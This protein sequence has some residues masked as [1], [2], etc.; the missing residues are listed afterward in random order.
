MFSVEAVL[1]ESSRSFLRCRARCGCALVAVV[2]PGG[3]SGLLVRFPGPVLASGDPRAVNARAVK[4]LI[5]RIRDSEISG[6][7]A[8]LE[9]SSGSQG[10]SSGASAKKPH[11]F[12]APR[13]RARRFSIAVKS[14][15][16]A[17]A[18]SAGY[19]LLLGMCSTLYIDH[20][21]SHLHPHLPSIQSPRLP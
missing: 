10:G 19:P 7:P 17:P 4:M 15:F 16:R 21:G 5:R 9:T 3:V 12:S 6:R 18:M 14:T 8:S 20:Y 1:A 13:D 2:R 11:F